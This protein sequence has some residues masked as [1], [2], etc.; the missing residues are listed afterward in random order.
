MGII[1]IGILA[2]CTE[3]K[4]AN[5]NN[6]INE[7]NK[8]IEQLSI[9]NESLKNTVEEQKEE[10]EHLR[11]QDGS[12]ISAATIETYPR[13]LY[14]KITLDIDHDDED[15]IIELYV[16]ADKIEDGSFAWDD[17]QN[18]LLIV[19]DDEKT[20]PLFDGYVQLGSIDFSPATF[21]G[22]SGIVMIET[23]HANKYIHRFVYHQDEKGYVKETIYKKENILQQYNQPASYSI[24]TDA[25]GILKQTFSDKAINDFIIDNINLKEQQ[26]PAKFFSKIQENLWNAQ[27]LF[28]TAG[29]LNPDLSVSLSNTILFINQMK[30]E[31]PTESQLNQLRNLHRIFSEND[32][33]H[34]FIEEENVLHPELTEKLQTM[35]RII[36]GK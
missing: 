17:G 33:T 8:Q 28:E 1:L 5:Q 10:L 24:I 16:N 7:L 4:N 34:L 3:Q 32:I 2:G 6:E 20:Y 21:E 29:E 18:W 26:A 35:D 14:K 12:I 15:E 36:N 30:K 9:E 27:Q 11:N 19:K 23:G 13:S 22:Q 31:Q 25:Y